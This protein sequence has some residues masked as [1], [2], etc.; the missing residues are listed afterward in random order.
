[1]FWGFITSF[2]AGLA[3]DKSL[4]KLS[5]VANRVDFRSALAT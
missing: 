3:K 5:L 1:M 4:R 2:S